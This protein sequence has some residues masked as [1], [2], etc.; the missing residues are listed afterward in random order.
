MTYDECINQKLR[1]AQSIGFKPP[2]PLNK[3]LFEWQIPILEW[4]IQRGRAALF[5][6]TGTGKTLDEL[7]WCRQVHAHTDLPT[8]IC[9]PLVV[10]AQT[11]REGVKFGIE[12]KH[13]RE[14]ADIINGI[15]VVNYDRVNKFEEIK[16]GGVAL[17]EASILRDFMGKTRLYLTERFSDTPYRSVYTA[18]PA[19]NDFEEI[20]TQAEFLGICSYTQML[21]TYFINDTA[22]TG[23]WRLKKHAEDAFWKWVAS[24]GIAMSKPSDLGFSDEGFI[25]PPLNLNPVWVEVD[26]RGIEG[27]GQLLRADKLSAMTFH[28]E[29]RLTLEDRIKAV[30]EIVAGKPNEPWAVWCNID[31]EQR[32]LEKALK[33]KCISVFGSLDA[34]EKEKRILQWLDGDQPYFVT[35]SK[36]C[37]RGMN[38][39]HC[40]N[41]IYFPTF[42]F[43]DY[44]QTIRRF[45][46]FGQTKPVN[47]YVVLPRTAENVMQSIKRKME[48]H[49]VMR[50]LVKFSKDSLITKEDK[51]TVI[52]TEIKTEMSANWTS[53]LGDAVR[54]AREKIKDESVGFSVFSP[55]FADLFTYSNDVQD[56]GNCGGLA[57]F[58]VQ[59]GFLIDELHRV[60]M[61]GREVAV[62]CCDLMATKW[63]HG[64]IEFQD[65]SGEISRAF[66]AR[67]FLLHSRITIWKSPVVEQERTKA[68]GLL[69]KTMLK[70]S[71]C[72]RVGA[73]DYLLVIRKRGV[74]PKPINH[75]KK[76]FPLEQWQEWASP[77]W[78]TVDQG[79]VMKNYKTARAG[80][81]ERHICPL[82]L[83]VINR[84]LVLWSRKGDLVYSPFSGVASEGYC[85][86]KKGRKFIGS[87]LKKEYWETGLTNMRRADDEA[88]DLFSRFENQE[89]PA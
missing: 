12:A 82:Q 48:Q 8:L 60:M 76:S 27:S 25:L 47:C 14:P 16:F 17:D 10:A 62:H 26:E 32:A 1:T 30:Q 22:D 6:D 87:E 37:G 5:K 69:Q 3:H 81:D 20:G 72:A 7:E 41:V 44:Y 73:P 83:D 51:P 18:T 80:K 89:D 31:V 21:A 29:M 66:R 63:K 78:M 71:S 59:F 65:F 55:P 64:A 58:M 19:P 88:M 4:A 67:Q 40:Q 45:W 54:V 74:N 85:S 23:T 75:T 34:D 24:W 43:E 84:A 9:V 52:N 50:E 46:R 42:S 39:Q 77:V 2:L 53:H 57:D 28:Q 68:H 11:V 33:G 86:V 13:V 35:K 56:M 36:I 15:N 61:P 38:F 79:N 49:E 70:D